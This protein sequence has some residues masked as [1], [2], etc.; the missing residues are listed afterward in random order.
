MGLRVRPRDSTMLCQHLLD[1]AGILFLHLIWSVLLSKCLLKICYSQQDARVYG[2]GG[3]RRAQE[4][5]KT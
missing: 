2:N 5:P 3:G 1:E 4:S